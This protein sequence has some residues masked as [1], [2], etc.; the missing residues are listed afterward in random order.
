MVSTSV[1]GGSLV[2]VITAGSRYLEKYLRIKE[3]PV[4]C[5][6]KK[7]E[8]KNHRFQLSQTPQRTVGFHG[9]TNGF[10]GSHFTFSRK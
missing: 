5:M 3:L 7:S 10:G 2:F 8:S 1:G 9:R 4:L 6:C